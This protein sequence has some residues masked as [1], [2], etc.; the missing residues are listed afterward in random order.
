MKK[1][2]FNL[3]LWVA[4]AGV[5][6]ACSKSQTE[7]RR[8]EGAMLGTFMQVHMRRH[9]PAGDDGTNHM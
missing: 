7:Y 5:I 2:L 6:S 3:I 1:H 4:V 9:I 8:V